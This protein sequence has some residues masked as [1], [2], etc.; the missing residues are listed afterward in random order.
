MDFEQWKGFEKGEWKRQIDVRSFIQKNYTP[1]VGDSSFLTGTTEKTKKLWD[2]VLELYKKEQD[3]QGGVLDIDTKTIS[4]VSSHEA[5]YI[6]KDLEEIVGVQTDAPLKRA[7]MP[8]GG[9]RIVE[10]SCEAYGREVDPETDRIF[11]IARKTHNDGVF[12]VYTPDIRAARSSHLITGLPDGYGRGRIIG[13]YRRVALYGVDTLIEE[14]KEELEILNV[15]DFTEKVIRE[16][17]EISEQIKAL[18]QLKVMAQKYG[19]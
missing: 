8:F 2:E 7:I 11:H 19:F 10:K 14:K 9:I 13:D 17:E 18:N 12:D 15:D 3:A 6:D 4:T 16:R 5:G 1:Y